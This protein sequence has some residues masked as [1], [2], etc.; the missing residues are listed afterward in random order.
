MNSTNLQLYF[1][2]KQ[3]PEFAIK[4][5]L[6][7]LSLNEE[8]FVYALR[9]VYA[10]S[11]LVG[12]PAAGAQISSTAPEAFLSTGRIVVRFTSRNSFPLIP[13]VE[14]VLVITGIRITPD[15][16]TTEGN[17][18]TSIQLASEYVE[19]N[20]FSKVGWVT[21]VPMLA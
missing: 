4:P 13:D 5:L 6:K 15:S 19:K 10:A 3:V 18:A 14:T 17:V 21:P 11:A 2:N 7:W 16:I 1:E 9:N 12:K 8:T 20:I